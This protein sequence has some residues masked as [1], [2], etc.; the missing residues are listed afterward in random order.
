VVNQFQPRASL[1]KRLVEELLEEGLPVMDVKLSASVKMK[2]SHQSCK[3]LI[4]FAP[5]HALTE[6]FLALDDLLQGE[7]AD[8]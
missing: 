7:K 2:E 1:P 6:Q 8:A 3:P 4:Y 5:K